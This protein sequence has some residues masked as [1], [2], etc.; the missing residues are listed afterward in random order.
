MAK[1]QRPH[2][3]TC[4]WGLPR[5]HGACRSIGWVGGALQIGTLKL[6]LKCDM[7]YFA[8][9]FCGLSTILKMLRM[10]QSSRRLLPSL[11]Y[12][13]SRYLGIIERRSTLLHTS[14]LNH[15]IYSLKLS[16]NGHVTWS[17]RKH[18]PEEQFDVPQRPIKLSLTGC[19]FS[20]SITLFAF[21]VKQRRSPNSGCTSQT[22][23]EASFPASNLLLIAFQK[24]YIIQQLVLFMLFIVDTCPWDRSNTGSDRVGDCAESSV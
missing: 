2:G 21:R 11:Q 9:S 10:S 20:E 19:V 12:V 1:F 17:S 16:S 23:V 8:T 22:Y 4:W 24:L 6:Q 15:Y 5:L 14:V 3:V 13:L 18:V 7:V